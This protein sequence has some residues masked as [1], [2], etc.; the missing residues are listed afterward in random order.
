MNDKDRPDRR[1]FFRRLLRIATFG[2]IAGG[3]A[4]LAGRRQTRL[5]R[6]QCTNKGV[7][8]SCGAYRDCRLPAALSA[9]HAQDEHLKQQR[10]TAR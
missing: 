3:G 4:V 5:S 9:K 1:E 2:A 7:C 8:C 6:Q 10:D